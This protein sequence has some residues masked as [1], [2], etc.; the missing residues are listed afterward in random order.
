MNSPQVL[1]APQET[2]QKERGLRRFQQPA[3]SLPSSVIL[4][5]SQ[6]LQLALPLRAQALDFRPLL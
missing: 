1:L 5:L 6:V 3:Q 2:C 4:Q